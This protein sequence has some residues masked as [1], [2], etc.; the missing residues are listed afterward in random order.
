VC[1]R[2]PFPFLLLPC[3]TAGIRTRNASPS[4]SWLFERRDIRASRSLRS[5]RTRAVISLLPETGAESLVITA[6]R[7]LSGISNEHSIS[8]RLHRRCGEA[9]SS[10]L[11]FLDSAHRETNRE[12]ERERDLKFPQERKTEQIGKHRLC[13]RCRLRGSRYVATIRS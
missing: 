7:I 5:A 11:R 8:A 2:S 13:R 6:L 9:A 1:H 4:S 10:C 12:R 3:T